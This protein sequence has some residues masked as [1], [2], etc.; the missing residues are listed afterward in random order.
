MRTKRWKS[1]DDYPEYAKLRADLLRDYNPANARE[2]LLVTEIACAWR[3]LNSAREREEAFHSLTRWLEADRVNQPV[4]K[5][6]QD[7]VEIAAFIREQRKG[8][9]QV[10]QAIRNAGRDFDRAIAR[11]EKVQSDRFRRER[12]QAK[13]DAKK[14]QPQIIVKPKIRTATAST[15][16]IPA[17]STD[18]DTIPELPRP[19]DL[20]SPRAPDRNQQSA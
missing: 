10:L 1:N 9:D 16:P 18:F 3:R 11:L 15:N 4:E 13:D 5:F 8:Y 7:G 12:L 20:F 2:E 17:D 14:P 6:D 19:S